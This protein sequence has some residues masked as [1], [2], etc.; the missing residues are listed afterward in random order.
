MAQVSS[1]VL[2]SRSLEGGGADHARRL[3]LGC[4]FS[5]FATSF[6]FI[7]RALVI[8]EWGTTF[9]LTE[10][11]KGAIFPGA[12]LFPF[13]I[14]IVLFSL[15]IDRIG[16]GKT[17]AF[18]CIGHLVGTLVTIFAG[19]SSNPYA[20]L[21]LGTF[22]TSLANG[23]IEAVVN[24]VVATIYPTEK[25]HRLNILHAG[26]PGGLVVAGVLGIL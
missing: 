19:R 16:Y 14:T 17:M 8:T 2:D 11:Q 3:F 5:M 26:W 1:G 4:F 23:A 24:P 13:A 7:V 21:Y 22:I 12:A 15:F 25:T 10:A 6:A 9:N 18:A 20:M